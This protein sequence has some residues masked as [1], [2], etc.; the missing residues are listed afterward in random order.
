MENTNEQKKSPLQEITDPFINLIKAPRALWGINLSYLIEGLTYFGVL[1][2]LAIYYNEYIGLNDIEA[3]IMVGI[4]TWGITLAMLFLGATVDWIGVRKALLISL[5]LF[6][7]GRK[8]CLA[9]R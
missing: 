2:L 5:F 1:G 3:G 4:L 7:F 8:C 9:S 6:L